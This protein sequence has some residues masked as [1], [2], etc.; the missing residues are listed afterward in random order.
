VPH[1]SALAWPS[2]EQPRQSAEG[3]SGSG[4][5]YIVVYRS[6]GVAQNS[7]ATAEQS[8]AKAAAARGRR[9]GKAV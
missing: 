3:I 4:A 5:W 6:D 7:M 9:T 2:D 8:V 1:G